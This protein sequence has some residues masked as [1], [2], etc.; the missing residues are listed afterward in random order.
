MVSLVMWILLISFAIIVIEKATTNPLDFNYTASPN[1]GGT[2]LAEVRDQVVVE[3]G[4]EEEVGV[5]VLVVAEGM[6]HRLPAQIKLGAGTSSGQQVASSQG[7]ADATE[8]AGLAGVSA[9]QLQQLLDL[10]SLAKTKD[11]L[12]GPTDEEGDW[13]G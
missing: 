1:G 2:G 12:Y 7:L 8:A 9:T 6:V 5:Q 13:R 3:D 11:R 4:H 10:L